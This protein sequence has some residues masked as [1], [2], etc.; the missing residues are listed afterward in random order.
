MFFLILDTNLQTD[1]REMIISTLP[2]NT[3]FFDSLCMA[4][5]FLWTVSDILKRWKF[6]NSHVSP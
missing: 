6:P 5:K 1:G 3:I 4:G 2:S